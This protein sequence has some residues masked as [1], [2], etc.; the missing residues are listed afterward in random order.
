MTER[1][2]F[3]RRFPSVRTASDDQQ[4]RIVLDAVRFDNAQ[5]VLPDGAVDLIGL[6]PGLR[7]HFEDILGEPLAAHCFCQ[8]VAVGRVGFFDV[9]LQ[10][11]GRSNLGARTQKD[12]DERDDETGLKRAV[13]QI[14]ESHEV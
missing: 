8:L 14:H 13:G 11:R 12:A 10:G 3:R 2:Y 7:S 9:I 4:P 6:E 5:P 1:V